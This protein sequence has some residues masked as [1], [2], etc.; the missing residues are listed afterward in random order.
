MHPGSSRTG[1]IEMATRDKTKDPESG[2]TVGKNDP[3]TCNE[4][5]SRLLGYPMG[6]DLLPNRFLYGTDLDDGTAFSD[7]MQFDSLVDAVDNEYA[8]M[9]AIYGASNAAIIARG[10][11][12]KSSL[13][14]NY[15]GD[16]KAFK[17]DFS[18]YTDSW[19]ELY[20]EQVELDRD[21]LLRKL[22][23]AA[24]ASRNVDAIVRSKG[25]RKASPS[26]LGQSAPP[27]LPMSA[28]RSGSPASANS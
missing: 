12:V 8:R 20:L 27:L 2:C 7:V 11:A 10:M 14:E 15:R 22:E 25:E 1:G 3:H 17:Q 19:T 9:A 23:K 18:T 26:V 28:V 13:Y 24:Q 5:R 21:H 16:Y 6:C 4:L